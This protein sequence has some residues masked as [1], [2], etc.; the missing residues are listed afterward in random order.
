MVG[1]CLRLIQSVRGDMYLDTWT[2]PLHGEQVYLKVDV[3]DTQDFFQVKE[4]KS[5]RWEVV[6]SAKDVTTLFGGFT[7]NFVGVG[8][9]DLNKK[10]GSY[11]DFSFFEYK[12]RD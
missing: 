10:K 9:H 8:V 1:K 3:K 4:K 5:E 12:G 7:G 2:I 11:A 6:G